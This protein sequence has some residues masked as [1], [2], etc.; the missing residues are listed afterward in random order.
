MALGSVL[1]LECLYLYSFC[2]YFQNVSF[3]DQ[4]QW[5]KLWAETTVHKVLTY[6]EYRAVF[7][8]FQNI[9]PPPHPLSTQRVCPSPDQR[10]GGGGY[11]LAGQWGGGGSIFWKTLDIGLA[12]YRLIALR[13]SWTMAKKL[14][15]FIAVRKCLAIV[16]VFVCPNF[17]HVFFIIYLNPCLN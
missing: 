17:A 13:H 5:K 9:D 15:Q 4:C 8:V 1:T 3:R 6:V 7:G 16:K 11:T 10:R 14:K 12:S 2:K